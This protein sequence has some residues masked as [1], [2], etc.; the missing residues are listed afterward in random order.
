MTKT[1]RPPGGR[2][3]RGAL[4]AEWGGRDAGFCEGGA[5]G[6]GMAGCRGSGRGK[7][8]SPSSLGS[9]WTCC[10]PP[11]S[12]LLGRGTEQLLSPPSSPA[13]CPADRKGSAQSAQGSTPKPETV[14]GPRPR[15]R[16]ELETVFW[17][18]GGGG[19]LEFGNLAPGRSKDADSW[20]VQ[21]GKVG[22]PTPGSLSE[23]TWALLPRTV[24]KSTRLGKRGCGISDAGV[25]KGEGDEVALRCSKGLRGLLG[26]YKA[27]HLGRRGQ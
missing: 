15:G 6:A 11:T 13:T 24:A 20:L 17:A 26:G 22:A 19:R 3:R 25:R 23:M 2:S 16:R 18:P 4:E 21:G 8:V 1:T 10:P 5:G 14:R 27:R 9:C 12:G 7:L